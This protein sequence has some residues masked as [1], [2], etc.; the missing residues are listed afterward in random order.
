MWGILTVIQFRSYLPA[1]YLKTR[2]HM[3][4]LKDAVSSISYSALAIGECMYVEHWSDHTDRGK[5]NHPEKDLPSA[6]LTTTNN[7]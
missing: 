4:L 3:Y 1:R 5:W 7:P 2:S 6:T